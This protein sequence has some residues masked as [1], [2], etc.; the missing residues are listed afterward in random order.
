MG[1]IRSRKRRQIEGDKEIETLE[2]LVVCGGV[3]NL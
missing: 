1:V 3:G 2:G